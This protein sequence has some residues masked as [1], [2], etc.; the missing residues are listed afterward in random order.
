MLFSVN[1]I[2]C[3][4]VF[5]IID[6]L[7]VILLKSVCIPSG[8]NGFYLDLDS[9]SHSLTSFERVEYHATALH[10]YCNV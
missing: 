1:N 7:N 9:S 4:C 8:E 10:K 3:V 5:H 6:F 2:V